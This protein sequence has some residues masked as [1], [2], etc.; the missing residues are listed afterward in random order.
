MPDL[1]DLNLPENFK[2]P[3]GMQLPQLPPNI[4]MPAPLQNMLDKLNLRTQDLLFIYSDYL[5]SRLNFPL[6]KVYQ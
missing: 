3:E 1:G 6:Y 2:L 5:P 4:K